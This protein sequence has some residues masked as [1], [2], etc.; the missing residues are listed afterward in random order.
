MHRQVAAN[1]NDDDELDVDSED[2][3]DELIDALE[4]VL[5]KGPRWWGGA[6]A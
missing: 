5:G 3:D 1:E 6:N 2:L 4:E